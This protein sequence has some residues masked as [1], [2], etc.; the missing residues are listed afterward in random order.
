MN[1]RTGIA[2]LLAVCAVLLIVGFAFSVRLTAG[3][4]H[5]SHL[6]AT[7]QSP[8]PTPPALAPAKPAS[9]HS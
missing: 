8:V 1:E 9:A 4:N 5:A 7:Q 6:E 2:V 3:I